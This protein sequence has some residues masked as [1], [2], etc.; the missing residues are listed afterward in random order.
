M[1]LQVDFSKD[2]V[3]RDVHYVVLSWADRVEGR[4]LLLHVISDEPVFVC[5][6]AVLPLNLRI[7]RD[8]L[9]GPPINS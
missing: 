7:M 2:I 8:S 3:R 9:L 1:R 4:Q 5:Q 6:L